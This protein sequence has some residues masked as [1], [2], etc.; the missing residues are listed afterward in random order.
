MGLVAVV[1]TDLLYCLPTLTVNWMIEL[2]A[3]IAFPIGL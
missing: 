3:Q 2:K 1:F